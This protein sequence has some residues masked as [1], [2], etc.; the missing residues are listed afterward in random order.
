MYN[1]FLKYS[2]ILILAIGLT[3]PAF[4]QGRQTG[5][6]A[7]I[8]TNTQGEPLPGCTI[9]LSGPKLQ[10]QKI[11]I[12]YAS[13]RFRFLAL[14]PGGDYELVAEI[15]GF[16][17]VVRPGLIVSVGKV[18]E[19]KI[20]LDTTSLEEEVIVTASS[21]TVD[22]DTAKYSVNYS[23]DFIHSLPINRDLY[24]LQNSVPGAVT[25]GAE[26]RRT[27]SILGG[28]VRSTLYTLDGVPMN[29]PATFYSMANIN[30]DVY[31]EIEI[32]VGALPA[33]IGQ[34]DSAHINIVT[35]SGG[36][37]F[38]GT[39]S[40]YYSS[41]NLSKDLV[42][43]EDIEAL[44]VQRPA[45]Y[46]NYQ[47]FSLNFGGPIMEDKLWFFING[48]RLLWDRLNHYTPEN[49]M[50][51]LGIQSPHFD[52]R[53]EEWLGFAK[54]TFQVMPNV[55]YFGMVHFNRMYEPYY[56]NR[57][58][59][60]RSVD[61]VDIWDNE[62]TFT[63]THQLNWV[64]N[65]N[66]FMDVRGT[67]IH[68]NFPLHHREGTDGNY[69]YFDKKEQVYW[70]RLE[71][72][73]EYVRSKMLASMAFTKFE[74]D[75]LG[76]S[77]EIKIGAEFEDAKYKRDWYRA[78]PYYS[79]WL[80]YA[81]GDPYYYS[82]AERRGLLRIRYCPPI[83]G[84]W[85]IEDNVR[86]VSAYVQDNLK[87]GRLAL[88]LG[89]RFDWSYQYQPTQ[90][91]PEL[92]YEYGPE[93]Q[94][95][96]LKNN[97]LLN[98]LIDQMQD[99]GLTT[100]FDSLTTSWKKVV[101]F[102]TFS[103]RI[104]FVFDLFGNGK[105]A[106]KF[107]YA[108]YYEPVWAAKYNASQIFGAGSYQWYWEDDNANKLMDLPGTDT[109]QLQFTSNQDP[110]YSYYDENLK[111]PY[112][113]EFLAGVEHELTKDFRIGL[114]FIRKDNRNI[115]EDVDQ[116][117]GYDPNETDEDGLIW[118]PYEFVDPGLDGE[119]GTTDDQEMT[120]YGLREDRPI[121][122]KF[123]TNPPEAKRQYYAGI[124]TLSKRMS[125]NWQ[126]EGS[127]LYS[128][129][130][131]NVSAQYYETEGESFAFDTPNEQINSYGRLYFDRPLQIRLMAS[132]ILPLDFI[133]SAYFQHLSG[134]NW[135]RTIERVYLPPDL[136]V[137]QSF[138]WVRAEERGA[139][140]IQSYTNLD[141]RLEKSFRF[142]D[143]TSL[144]LLVDIFNLLGQNGVNYYENPNG[145]LR[146]Y[147]NPPEYQ[148]D[149]LFGTASNV[150]G[151]RS[152][153]LGVRFSF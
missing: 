84:V 83:P 131:G 40:G 89:L 72:D 122:E 77:H 128:S 94:N 153:R 88:N 86:R 124:L 58:A 63:T 139:N 132:A 44:D 54:V 41:D 67:Y 70:G 15:P 117:N 68:R 146:Y 79:Y 30:V 39:I 123:G 111:A 105:T 53:H 100:P 55:R 33:E 17:T 97:D 96:N 51:N 129:F 130:K 144:N 2:L 62:N 37:N 93:L 42:S 4:S 91:R 109:Y 7:G 135:T 112:V 21:P 69:T 101:D 65:Q 142:G 59:D 152:F 136:G 20:L 29:D 127:I 56:T 143:N 145:R 14:A 27:S 147:Q 71:F 110:E 52:L 5:S 140:R 9:Y 48:R 138:V 134:S 133:F 85:N 99:A 87:K 34:T 104:G 121:P 151:V 82:S 8:I 43:V 126:F 75:F 66:T 12:T 148:T 47:D 125:N 46:T 28:T 25:D 141:L 18:T 108:R 81:A 32:G 119:F 13:G 38:S 113:N 80:D 73:D 19:V 16:K 26:H 3:S 118:I 23:A 114:Q 45:A 150:Y 24:G 64:F 137:Q 6:I 61:V 115:V 50:A 76:S 103:P 102:T 10:G 36:N 90:F 106:L 78:N 49:R 107:N 22:I 11:Y 98:A 1:S 74:D 120:V 35:K 92:R 31:D 60:N 95:P 116:F 57:F 149:P